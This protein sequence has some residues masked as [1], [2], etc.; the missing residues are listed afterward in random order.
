MPNEVLLGFDPGGD[1]RFGWCVVQDAP[2]PPLTM[3][4]SDVESSPSEAVRQALKHASSRSIA[5]AGIDAP[6][7]WVAAGDRHVDRI[8]RQRLRALGGRSA[9]STVMPVN[10]LQGAC[11]V[12]G[13]MTAVVLRQAHRLLPI[14]ES[15]PKAQLWLREC[16]HLHCHPREVGIA[17]LSWLSASQGEEH[18]RDAALAALSAWAMI[19]RPNGWQDLFLLEEAP[20]SPIEAPLAYWMPQIENG[21]AS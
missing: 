2:E 21:D 6:L 1:K 14:T 4:S 12:G 18:E 16:Q 17:Q 7:F 20:W 13:M 15:H 3:I 8:L 5:A 10:A 11:L 9:A 19:H